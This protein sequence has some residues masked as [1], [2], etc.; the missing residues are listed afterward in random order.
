MKSDFPEHW[1]LLPIEDCMA[2]IIDYRGK[3]PQKTSSGVPLITA[4]VVKGGRI[5]PPDEFIA[6][7]DYDSWMR[8]GLPEP[9]DVVIT[10]EAPLGEVGQIGLEKVALAQRLIVL[11]GK[12]NLLDNTYLKFAL[13]SRFVQAQL[14]ATRATAPGSS[15]S[16]REASALARASGCLPIAAKARTPKR[17]SFHHM[18]DALPSN[19]SSSWYRPAA[20]N[21]ERQTGVPWK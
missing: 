3:S 19:S 10:T 6:F 5:L 8:R 18:N 17:R 16:P 1:T 4:K 11:R 7:G 12:P 9:G 21:D 13:Q 20:S 15:L 14:H 2:A